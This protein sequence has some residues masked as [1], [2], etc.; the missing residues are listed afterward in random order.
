[1]KNK[2]T[3]KIECKSI[4]GDCGEEKSKKEERYRDGEERERERERFE[5]DLERERECLRLR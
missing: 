3:I 1:M 4:G 5:R 2:K